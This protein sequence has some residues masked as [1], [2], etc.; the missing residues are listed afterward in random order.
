M[1]NHKSYLNIICIKLVTQLK[2]KLKL[3]FLF[4]V[5]SLTRLPRHTRPLNASAVR[6][7]ILAAARR[8][9]LHHILYVI[10]RASGCMT[11]SVAQLSDLFRNR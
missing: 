10:R 1:S 4:K 8:C 11:A 5:F 9:Y 2:K 7:I 6:G 3:R